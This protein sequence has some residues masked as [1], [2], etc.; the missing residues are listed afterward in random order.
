MH[1]M[2]RL[3]YATDI[4]QNYISLSYPH[5]IHHTK[6][7]QKVDKPINYVMIKEVKQIQKSLYDNA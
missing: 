6:Y 4:P 2:Y 1:P 7:M 3:S 5:Y